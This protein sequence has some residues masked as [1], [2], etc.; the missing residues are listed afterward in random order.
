MANR[1]IEAFRKQYPN[2]DRTDAELLESI[3]TNYPDYK[4][5]FPDFASDLQTLTKRAQPQP[6]APLEI[7]PYPPTIGE[8]GKQFFGSGVRGFSRTLGA[9]PEAVGS[10][11]RIAG[12]YSVPDAEYVPMRFETEPG[13]TETALTR[14]GEAIAPEEVPGLEKSFF[15][16]KLPAAVASGAAFIVGG[17]A[18]GLAER[19]LVQAIGTRAF[20]R[21]VTGGIA[22]EAALKIGQEAMKSAATRLSYGNVA[23]LGALSQAQQGYEEARK[24]G[25]NEHDR[26]LAYV[27]NL[28]VGMTEAVPLAKMLN[29]LDEMSGGT[30]KESLL[31]AGVESLEEAIQNSFQGVAGDVIASKLAKYEPD[32]KLFSSIAEDASIGA[33]SGAILS[34]AASAIGGKARTPA[35]TA[36]TPPPPAAADVAAQYASDQQRA[37]EHSERILAA[38]RRSVF[39]GFGTEDITFVGKLSPGD[40]AIYQGL[41]E[42]AGKDK[43]AAQTRTEQQSDT[44]ERGGNAAQLQAQGED[45]QG[46]A[47]QQGSRAAGGTGGG[48]PVGGAVPGGLASDV[49]PGTGGQP[50][51]APEKEIVAPGAKPFAPVV[52]HSVMAVPGVPPVI[53]YTP[54]TELRGADGGLYKPGDAITQQNLSEFSIPP[55]ELQKAIDQQ[56]GGI[57]SAAATIPAAPAPVPTL[58]AQPT[59]PPASPPPPG[60]PADLE[61]IAQKVASPT[62]KLTNAE[63]DRIRKLLAT[64]PVYAIYQARVAQ[65]RGVPIRTR[66]AVAAVAPVAQ[67]VVAEEPESDKLPDIEESR[68]APSLSNVYVPGPG[69]PAPAALPI[70]PTGILARARAKAVALATAAKRKIASVIHASPILDTVDFGGNSPLVFELS[71]Q[72]TGRTIGVPTLAPV[73]KNAV[74]V[75]EG[76][77]EGQDGRLVKSEKGG[78]ELTDEEI[79]QGDWDQKDTVFVKLKNGDIIKAKKGEYKFLSAIRKE[80]Q[81]GTGA[82][83]TLAPT[84]FEL[85]VTPAANDKALQAAGLTSQASVTGEVEGGSRNTWTK[86]WTVFRNGNTIHFFP[87]YKSEKAIT[88]AVPGRKKGIS[89]VKLMAQGFIPIASFR[90]KTGVHAIRAVKPVMGADEYERTFASHARQQMGAAARTYAAQAA[91]MEPSQAETRESILLPRTTNTGA[92]AMVEHEF[93][94]AEET[95]TGT[96]Q[97][98]GPE[99]PVEVA[100]SKELGADIYDRLTKVLAGTTGRL[101]PEST[102]EVLAKYVKKGKYGDEIRTEAVAL[103]Q[104]IGAE[105]ASR[106]I[107]K[108]IIRAY[109]NSSSSKE[110]AEAISRPTRGT[111]QPA[112]AGA[113][114]RGLPGAPVNRPGRQR[115]QPRSAL[116]SGATNEPVVRQPVP[117]LTQSWR[118][119]PKFRVAG[120]PDVTQE[121]DYVP[122]EQIKQGVSDFWGDEMENYQDKIG[123]QEGKR[124]LNFLEESVDEFVDWFF[125]NK[126]NAKDR[127]QIL[128]ALGW[129]QDL[130]PH[131]FAALMMDILVGNPEEGKGTLT[132]TEP[133]LQLLLRAIRFNPDID[134]MAKIVNA[135]SDEAKEHGYALGRLIE[136]GLDGREAE[137]ALGDWPSRRADIYS[138]DPGL[139]RFIET[140]LVPNYRGPE[141]PNEWKERVDDRAAAD[142]KF[143]VRTDGYSSQ[144]VVA[145][146]VQ[147]VLERLAASG[148]NVSVVQ[149][150]LGQGGFLGRTGGKT[151][152]NAVTLVMAD[153]TA[154][155]VEDWITALHESVHVLVSGESREM[156]ERMH[157]AIERLSDA[158]LGLT[159]QPGVDV[160]ATQENRGRLNPEAL[161]EE[162]LSESL[163][164]EGFDPVA[165]Q[166]WAQRIMRFLKDLYNRACMA[167]QSSIYGEDAVNPERV[168]E[169]Y[170][171]RLHSLLAGDRIPLS[172]VDTLGGKPMAY[173]RAARFYLATADTERHP[174][175]VDWGGGTVRIPFDA[176]ATVDAAIANVRNAARPQT[177][178]VAKYRQPG[179]VSEG[180]PVGGEN[181]TVRG[182]WNYAAANGTLSEL[183]K[184]YDAFNAKGYN[185]IL[186]AGPPGVGPTAA[187]GTRAIS[188]E[189]FIGFFQE[190]LPHPQAIKDGIQAELTAI[191]EPTVNP[192]LSTD[193]P[194]SFNNDATLKQSLAI[195]LKH[196]QQWLGNLTRLFTEETSR[197]QII[198]N[199]LAR[200]IDRAEKFLTQYQNLNFHFAAAKEAITDL[201]A[202]AKVDIRE[203]VGLAKHVGM[204][205]QSLRELQANVNDP[206]PTQYHQLIDK[207][208][209]R[210]FDDAEHFTEFLESAAALNVNWQGQTLPQIKAQLRVLL[211]TNPLFSSL[212]ADEKNVALALTASFARSN[213]H[214][215]AWLAV[216]QSNNYEAVAAIREM[217][218]EA[219]KD[220]TAGLN[221]AKALVPRVPRLAMQAQRILDHYLQ[222]RK[223]AQSWLA[224]QARNTRIM[225]AHDAAAPILGQAA[226]S[227]EKAL[228]ASRPVDLV[229]GA[230][231]PYVTNPTDTPEQIA[232][233]TPWEFHATGTDAAT[234]AQVG[235]M[236]QRYQAWIDAN[237]GTG[238]AMV[239]TLRDLVYRL[240]IQQAEKQ[241]EGMRPGFLARA[242]ASMSDACFASGSV[243][244]QRIGKALTKYSSLEGGYTKELS[245]LGIK[246]AADRGRAMKALGVDLQSFK[247]T[248][249]DGAFGYFEKRKDLQEGPNPREAALSAWRSAL[250]ANPTTRPLITPESW[251]KLRNYY[252]RCVEYNQAQARVAGKMGIRIKDETLGLVRDPIG[253]PLFTMPRGLNHRIEL[254]FKKMDKDWNG[255]RSPRMKASDMERQFTDDPTALQTSLR[256]RFNPEVWSLFVG[257]MTKRDGRSLF[258]GRMWAPG[259]WTIARVQNVQRAYAESGGDPLVF[260]TKL[261]EFEGNIPETRAAFV[262]E[263]LETFQNY[264]DAI[265]RIMA[266]TEGSA[267][268]FGL[269]KGVPRYL[270][271]ARVSEDFPTGWME[272]QNLDEYHARQ[273]VH[274]FA[275]HSAFGRNGGTVAADFASAIDELGNAAIQWAEYQRQ[276]RTANPTLTGGKLLEAARKLATDAGRNVTLLEN[277]EKNE[278]VLRKTQ[279]QLAAWF[280]SHN[281]DSVEPKVFLE[282]LSFLTG[283]MVQGPKTAI[284]NTMDL[285]GGPILQYGLN[286]ESL[287]QVRNNWGHFAQSAFGSLFQ[288]VGIQLNINPEDRLKLLEIGHTDPDNQITITDRFIAAT[289]S[290]APGG[291]ITRN[292]LRATRAARAITQAGLPTRTA[293]EG[294]YPTL[295]A[296]PF[297]MVS[298]WM[299]EAFVLG[300]WGRFRGFVGRGMEYLRAHPEVMTDPTFRFTPEMMGY[301]KGTFL[302][303]ALSF[304][305]QK[306]A[307]NRWGM[308]LEAVA[309]A[310][311]KPGAPMFTDEQH[312]A[313]AEM[314]LEE[315]SLE[316]SPNTAPRWAANPVGRFTMPLLR[317]SFAKTNQLRKSYLEPNG[318][319]N[320]HSTMS[321]LK[322]LALA[323]GTGIAYA[324]L[325][326]KYD[327]ELTG[328]KSNIRGFGQDNNFLAAVEM[329]ARMGSLGLWGDVANTLG[330]YAGTGDLRGLSIDN[331]VVF[332]NSL[333]NTMSALTTFAKQGEATYATVYRQ[334]LQAI[335]GSGYLQIAQIINNELSLDNAE[336]RVTGRINVNNWLRAVG[337]EMNLDVRIGRGAGAVTNANTI[338]PWVGEMILAA[339]ADNQSDFI[340]SYSK[341]VQAAREEGKPDPVKHV[342]QSYAAY[343]P[344]R[345]VYTTPPTEAEYRQIL[346]RLPTSGRQDVQTAMLLFAKYGNEIGVEPYE[347]KKE[348]AVKPPPIF[349]P[350]SSASVRGSV[351]SNLF[352]VYR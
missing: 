207:M 19:G 205:V 9:I 305:A 96:G 26:M 47:A 130:D 123:D 102:I 269:Q 286:K 66:P 273:A 179:V 275:F 76:I 339:M 129:E 15:A 126:N 292:L 243:V 87:T 319:Q 31:H 278:S 57:S 255:T 283:M 153:V 72:G 27:L 240:E 296:A 294:L 142:A 199:A 121:E 212:D 119:Q 248:F 124:A 158:A 5:R 7:T 77:H 70:A 1:V 219:R 93:P 159:G 175:V 3:D 152:G 301:Q 289:T 229:E 151:E 106:A 33:I 244:A 25:A 170:R 264:F 125:G 298:R 113:G 234:P 279:D 165:A 204:V 228:G 160:R 44:G 143:S 169:Y 38:A 197:R 337:R 287:R 109:N 310:A 188:F 73:A 316:S 299:N 183:Q 350:K 259:K 270:M 157:R 82:K 156:Q 62:G 304:E 230:K 250:L 13:G 69:Q 267:N 64:D 37:K 323:T 324:L 222:A 101:T 330:N 322:A 329:T 242:M 265:E 235:Q 53:Y 249:H 186:P 336:S 217:L 180:E 210:I 21:A 60:L 89:V 41:V 80:M 104:Q 92:V 173:E 257:E 161:A 201:I 16:T 140:Y 81:E 114:E 163:A 139:A 99:L 297:S 223:D 107:L 117:T 326:G 46:Q 45:R 238:G 314:A 311:M 58:G 348:V 346:A 193:G 166:G 48:V 84:Y 349:T 236:I 282:M 211:D 203:S 155:T 351:A 246:V 290:Q 29:R 74:L 285:F 39:G 51:T 68:P 144:P 128:K 35:T 226:R 192:D 136:L 181:P 307:M 190:G 208:G 30:L 111:V 79:D 164:L 335:G 95:V 127:F 306:E 32:R 168:I 59:A 233:A 49:A 94:G 135:Q 10:A 221:A 91:A 146:K 200:T 216:K 215:M 341:A 261:H 263:T 225:Q 198:S 61:A 6:N 252:E 254:L 266:D 4:T 206:L 63:I 154:P 232:A 189:N 231:L 67:P 185:P 40:L 331:R 88:A 209:K 277:A 17:G 284:I 281:E 256:S 172:F 112:V 167:I 28:P 122:P 342:Q 14:A 302:D 280:K 325:M 268:L 196:V 313:L 100:F 148:V 312:R 218:N 138:Q 213:D 132:I 171:N 34:L 352:P 71:G 253:D 23:G 75:S 251:Q 328:K 333:I 176:S 90:T 271:D 50:V 202:Q 78:V 220:T 318:K 194:V 108:H 214:Q 24:A 43:D 327:E 118:S 338:K 22:R 2:D 309:K 52:F 115:S 98:V 134:E 137:Q 321:G 317:W 149:R 315:M 141:D 150:L 120:E 8:Y 227:I 55:A 272:Y 162:R 300:N 239:E 145:A 147:L 20:E 274:R 56:S 105:N 344:L 184:T 347:G 18:A 293:G 182:G 260:A 12:T 85:P 54:T 258:S 320:L 237:S 224:A 86:R 133:E 303:D 83:T 36:T 177:V 295:K 288:T 42:Q 103:G 97:T 247:T 262:G 187:P 340:L 332:V 195:Q 245:T 110:F 241:T 65:L 131:T 276:A 291:V 11:A 174:V 345:T 116:P 334:L 191:G 343:H 308:S 178:D